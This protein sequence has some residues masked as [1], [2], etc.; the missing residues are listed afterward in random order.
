[1]TA[2]NHVGIDRFDEV[3]AEAIQVDELLLSLGATD[4]EYL[5][6]VVQTLL[7]TD[8]NPYQSGV[9]LLVARAIAGEV[10]AEV[11]RFAAAVKIVDVA[12]LAHRQAAPLA[13]LSP[14]EQPAIDAHLVVLA[15]D[16]LYAQ[17]AYITAG[18]CN[19]SVMA[20]LAEEIKAQCRREMGRLRADVPSTNNPGLYT[21]SVLG[22]GQLLGCDARMLAALR[23]YGAVLDATSQAAGAVPDTAGLLLTKLAPGAAGRALVDLV[24][25]VFAHARRELHARKATD[26]GN[27]L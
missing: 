22:T 19:L 14:T 7:D 3:R 5:Y 11:V 12:A 6:H 8:R 10:P 26:T 20:I 1:M 17:A 15:G 4:G 21:L 24:G 2:I 16:Y 25:D 13:A 23:E 27:Q 18:L 9:A